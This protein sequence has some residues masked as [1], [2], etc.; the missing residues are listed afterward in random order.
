LTLKQQKSK[1]WY[2]PASHRINVNVM[3]SNTTSL[4]LAV[5]VV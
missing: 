2:Y 4:I 1:R 3:R 5:L